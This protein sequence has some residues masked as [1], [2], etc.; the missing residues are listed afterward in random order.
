VADRYDHHENLLVS[1]VSHDPVI[2]DAVPPQAFQIAEERVA[3]TS[4]IFG[5]RNTFAQISLNFASSRVT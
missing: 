4:R 3:E 2:A 5:R 1:D